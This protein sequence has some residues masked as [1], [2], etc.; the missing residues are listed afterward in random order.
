MI[1]ATLIVEHVLRDM[2]PADLWIDILVN[3]EY[4]GSVGPFMTAQDRQIELGILRAQIRSLNE[5]S[6]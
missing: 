6:L 2:G 5:F 1:T 4:C 3:D